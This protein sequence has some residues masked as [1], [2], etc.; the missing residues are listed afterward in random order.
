MTKLIMAA[1]TTAMTAM[2]A[3]KPAVSVTEVCP[4]ALAAGAVADAEGDESMKGNFG[5]VVRDLLDG[6]GVDAAIS[7]C[8]A[9]YSGDQARPH[10]CRPFSTSPK[11]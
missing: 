2:P 1:R 5:E 7:R 6:P 4:E 8:S 9:R 10:I 11:A 3:L